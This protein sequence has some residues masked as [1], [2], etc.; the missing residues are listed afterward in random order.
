MRGKTKGRGAPALS[1]VPGTT[2]RPGVGELT[3]AGY[4]PDVLVRAVAALEGVLGKG[5]RA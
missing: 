4:D 3:L 1:S 5:E 2:L